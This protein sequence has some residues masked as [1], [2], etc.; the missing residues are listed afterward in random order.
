[1]HLE[2]TRDFDAPRDTVWQV[3]ND[4]HRLARLVP[5]IETVDIR[6]DDHWSA[7]VRVPLGLRTAHS[8]M[9]F[10]RTET[11]A[12]EHAR[13]EGTGHAPGVKVTLVTYFD[14]SDNAGGTTMR[15]RADVKLGGPFGALGGRALQPLA[16]SH[17]GR[18]L[19]GLDRQVQEAKA[20]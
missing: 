16:E 1:V 11:R 19:D 9:E 20:A 14:L 8:Q 3:L 4:P 5:L 12:P 7:R 15:W 17:V 18:L 2:G 13:L 10:H 6:D